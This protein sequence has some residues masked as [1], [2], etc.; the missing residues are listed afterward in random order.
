MRQI[1][2]EFLTAFAVTFQTESFW[3]W[4]PCSLLE[5]D[6]ERFKEMPRLESERPISQ[7]VGIGCEPEKTRIPCREMETP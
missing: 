3:H 5:M 7:S 4:G 2:C 6:G 1:D